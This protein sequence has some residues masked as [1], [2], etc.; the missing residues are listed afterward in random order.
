M[1]YSLISYCVLISGGG[2]GGKMNSPMGQGIV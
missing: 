1:R 2:G